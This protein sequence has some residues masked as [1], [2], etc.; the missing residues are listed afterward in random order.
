MKAERGRIASL[1]PDETIANPAAANQ[2]RGTRRCRGRAVQQSPEKV[3]FQKPQSRPLSV[4]DA[5]AAD[6]RTSAVVPRR[7]LIF[8]VASYY[9]YEEMKNGMGDWMNLYSLEYLG[10]WQ[11]CITT[12]AVGAGQCQ[13]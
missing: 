13:R 8:P 3:T 10:H 1:R 2:R 12:L 9:L 6:D 4:E 11:I 7:I 5:P